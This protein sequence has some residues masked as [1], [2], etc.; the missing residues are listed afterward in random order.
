M[1]KSKPLE[2]Q[3]EAAEKE[4]KQKETR[5]NELLQKKKERDEKAKSDRLKELGT[6][7]ENLIEGAEMLTN[8]EI[9]TLLQTALSAHAANE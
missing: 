3:I 6:I 1:S 2:E 7:V 8:E 5:L 9:K 4:M